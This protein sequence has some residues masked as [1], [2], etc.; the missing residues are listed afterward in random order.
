MW[1]PRWLWERYKELRL[2][3]GLNN[4]FSFK[5]AK[6]ILSY[7]SDEM[8]YKTLNKLERLNII[9]VERSKKDN[10]AKT[11]KIVLDLKDV[12]YSGLTIPSDYQPEQDFLGFSAATGS[13][14]TSG[15]AVFPSMPP[16]KAFEK[17]YDKESKRFV[18]IMP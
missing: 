4:S 18:T 15:T 3:I 1:I 9:C 10:R 2:R 13:M 17:M 7:D 14:A 12:P 8:I 5:Q 6:E 16:S 11:Y